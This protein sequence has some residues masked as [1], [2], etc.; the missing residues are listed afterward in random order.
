MK[1]FYYGLLAV[2]LCIILFGSVL[3]FLISSESTGFVVSGIIL[4]I[5][6]IAGLPIIYKF[7]RKEI[8]NEKK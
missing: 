2:I 1:N 6:F 4:I 8:K 7:I 5:L 3:P